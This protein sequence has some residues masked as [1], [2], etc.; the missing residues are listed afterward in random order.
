MK[1]IFLQFELYSPAT[2]E[3]ESMS[4]TQLLSYLE[5]GISWYSRK[6]ENRLLRT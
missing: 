1:A 4:N 5:Y 6:E 3:N 2:E